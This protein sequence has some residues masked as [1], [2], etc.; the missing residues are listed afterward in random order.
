MELMYLCRITLTVYKR[1]LCRANVAELR[2]Y[3]YFLSLTLSFR[4]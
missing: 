1:N 3:G 2:V 4:G